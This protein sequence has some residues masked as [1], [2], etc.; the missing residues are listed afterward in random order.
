MMRTNRLLWIA[1]ATLSIL[2]GISACN[3]Q[4]Y[5]T[6]EELDNE[7]INRYI[8]EKNLNVQRYKNTDLYYQIVRPGT[9]RDLNFR[10]QYPIVLTMNSLDGVFVAND[11]LISNNRYHDYLGYFPFGSIAAG[12]QNSPVERQDDLKYVVRDIL[13]KTNGQIRIIVPSR[14]TAWGRK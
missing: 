4:E 5:Q 7:N 2:F 13:G 12:T 14:L 9:G 1:F 6:I 8:Q 11:T 10:E 3:K